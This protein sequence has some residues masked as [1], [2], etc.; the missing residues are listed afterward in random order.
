MHAAIQVF[1][2]HYMLIP[3]VECLNFELKTEGQATYGSEGNVNR[4]SV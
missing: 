2:C 1:Y 4:P 3:F